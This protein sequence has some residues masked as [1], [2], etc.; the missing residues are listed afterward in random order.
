MSGNFT[1]FIVEDVA[2]C[3]KLLPKFI[4]GELRVKNAE[5]IMEIV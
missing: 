2:R 4:S 1:E 5:R 3:N